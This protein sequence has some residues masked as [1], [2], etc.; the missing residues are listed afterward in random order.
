MEKTTASLSASGVV[1]NPDADEALKFAAYRA[2]AIARDHEQ[3]REEGRDP[4][5]EI[6]AMRAEAMSLAW[7]LVRAGVWT[8]EH[9]ADIEARLKE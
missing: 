6:K 2:D 9:V 8:Q 7:D 1:L 3:R 4:H 5:P